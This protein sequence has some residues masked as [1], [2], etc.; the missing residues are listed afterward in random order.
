[1]EP[2]HHYIRFSISPPSADALSLRKA[3]QD[4]LAQAFGLVAANTYV[5]VLWL[6]DD[7]AEAVVRVAR[8]DVPRI[9]ASV[10]A[11]AGSPRLALLKESAFL[12]SLLSVAPLS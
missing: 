11:A 4:A 7:G 3:L 5:D 1:M 12:P 9:L 8:S 10:A 2:S 6:A